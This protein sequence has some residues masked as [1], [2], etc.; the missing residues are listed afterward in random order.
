VRINA[1]IFIQCGA[2]TDFPQTLVLQAIDDGNDQKKMNHVV[3]TL[4]PIASGIDTAKLP[5]YAHI[6]IPLGCHREHTGFLYYFHNSEHIA[7]TF[8]ARGAYPSRPTA[9]SV[10]PRLGRPSILVRPGRL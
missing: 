6:T 7:G 4:I 8:P 3:N 10:I 5:Q 9:R 2:N 1:I